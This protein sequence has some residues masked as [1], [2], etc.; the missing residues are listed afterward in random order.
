MPKTISVK[1]KNHFK[2]DVHAKDVLLFEQEL[3]QKRLDFYVNLTAEPSSGSLV[4]Y[5]LLDK[6]KAEIDSFLENSDII[7]LSETLE[8]SVFGDQRRFMNLYLKLVG[9]FI[10]LMLVLK[11]IDALVN[12]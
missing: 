1:F 8:Y 3:N 10:V 7:V 11:T 9:I 5:Y 6:D 4:Q 12:P 2:V